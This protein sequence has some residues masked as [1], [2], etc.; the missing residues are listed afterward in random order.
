MNLIK[1]PEEIK[2]LHA[3]GRIL[4]ATLKQ[5]AAAVKPGV[6]TLELNALAEKLLREAGAEPSFL[7]YSTH[8]SSPYPATLCTS[9]DSE[10]VHGIPKS[11]VILKTGQIIGLDLGCCYQGL[12]TDSAITVPVGKI[13]DPAVKLIQVARD[14]LVEAIKR[15]KAGAT[16]GDIGFTIQSY[17]EKNGFSVVRDLVGHGVGYAVHEEPA[18]PNFG[19]AG[20]G[21]KL[22]SGMV[23]AIEPM[24]NIGDWQVKVLDD[25][26]TVATMDGSLSAHFEHTVAV[27]DDGCEVL[28]Q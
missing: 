22:K 2:I 3:G 18:V 26:W 4:A 27:T 21:M 7:N 16:L 1:T 6:T 10:V 15:V 14:S 28:T 19:K 25:N 8:G 9:V 23:I 17:I 5:V 20:A 13:D 24:V 12:F 11:S